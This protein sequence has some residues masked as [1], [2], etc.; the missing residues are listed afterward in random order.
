[1]NTLPGYAS[2]SAPLQDLMAKSMVQ[3][4]SMKL[5]KFK[6]IKPSD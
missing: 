5:K 4:G 2:E 1:M 6:S 3:M